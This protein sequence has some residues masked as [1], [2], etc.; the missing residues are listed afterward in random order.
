VLHLDF[1]TEANA[2]WFIAAMAAPG[3]AKTLR[4]EGEQT[5]FRVSFPR[6]TADIV[7]EWCRRLGKQQ[8]V[9]NMEG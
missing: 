8:P 5:R 7:Q 9:E 6:E 4:R 3:T 2:D 1:A